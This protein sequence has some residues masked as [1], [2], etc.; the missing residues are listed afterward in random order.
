MA[1][2]EERM[3]VRL[4]NREVCDAICEYVERMRAGDMPKMSTATVSLHIPHHGDVFVVASGGMTATVTT[5]HEEAK[6]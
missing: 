3:I 1:D 4:T 5:G 6:P 2:I